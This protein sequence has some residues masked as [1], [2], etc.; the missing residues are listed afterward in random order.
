MALCASACIEQTPR[1][2]GSCS[3]TTRQG[4][5][6]YLIF[7]ACNLRFDATVVSPVT[8]GNVSI[9]AITDWLSWQTAVQHRLISRTPEGIGQKPAASPTTE[10]LS[11]CKPEAIANMTHTISFTSKDVDNNNYT[12]HTYWN[13]I[14][15]NYDVYRLGWLGCD[16]NTLYYSG[17]S[18]DPGYPFSIG[19]IG[20][21]IPE[22]NDESVS[23]QLE[24][25]FSE[26]CIPTPLFIT[27]LNTAFLVDVNT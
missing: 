21:V 7:F 26:R 12:D 22:T 8:G 16:G 2:V 3:I 6:P 9:G 11:S 18:T 19:S 23:Y 17:D 13:A 10:R 5:I 14:C 20:N 27:N 1:W 24:L 15:Q 25:S 4:G